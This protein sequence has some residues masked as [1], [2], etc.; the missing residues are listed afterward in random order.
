MQWYDQIGADIPITQG[1]L[2]YD[3][4]L[5]GWKPDIDISGEEYINILKASTRVISADVV[6][7]SQACDLEHNKVT[8]LILCTHISLLE[9]R[10]AWESEMRNQKQNPSPGAW[11]SH[12]KDICDG[13]VWNL[14]MLNSFDFGTCK[15]DILIVDFHEIFSVP[16]LFLETLLRKRNNLRIRLLPPYREHL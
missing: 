2:I 12:C 14:S 10:K 3:C 15:S 9:F 4:P 11:R 13:F 6:V 7:L 16:K 8:N 1:D 5:I